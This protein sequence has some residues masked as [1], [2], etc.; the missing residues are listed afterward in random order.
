[1]VEKTCK[2]E[3]RAGARVK[4]TAK[5]SRSFLI[6]R[7]PKVLPDRCTMFRVLRREEDRV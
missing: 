6:Y 1:M 3:R 2:D 7:H 5:D 4:E